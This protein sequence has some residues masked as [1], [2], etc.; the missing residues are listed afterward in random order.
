MT[1]AVGVFL[2]TD[3]DVTLIGDAIP[4]NQCQ[5]LAEMTGRQPAG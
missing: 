4:A 3:T 2:D 5:V 1:D